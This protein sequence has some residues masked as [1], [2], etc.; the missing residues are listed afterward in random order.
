[1][2]EECNKH[3]I[4]WHTKYLNERCNKHLIE[5][6]TKY[7]NEQC[8]EHLIGRETERLIK[9]RRSERNGAWLADWAARWVAPLRRRRR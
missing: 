4:K 8:N 1:M 3:L 5:Q 2:N 6:H 7:L 9:Q